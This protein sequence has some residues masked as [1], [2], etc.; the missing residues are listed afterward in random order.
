MMGEKLEALIM[1]NRVIYLLRQYGLH[2]I[3]QVH[4]SIEK[5]FPKTHA[6]V[7]GI[8]VPEKF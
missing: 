7:F 4:I 3:S 8:G 1:P 2:I 6:P 5:P